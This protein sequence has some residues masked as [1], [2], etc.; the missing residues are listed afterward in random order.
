LTADALVAVIGGDGD[1]LETL[2]D[3]LDDIPTVAEF[4]LRTLPTADYTVVSDLPAAAPSAADIKTA[5]EA[6]GS[7]LDHL[8]EMTENDGGVRRLTANALEQA[9]SGG[10][11]LTVED[12]VDGVLDELLSG[13]TDVGSVGAGI[14][15]AGSAGDPWST[16]LPGAYGAGTAGKLLS[17]AKAAIDTKA[18]PGDPMTIA[19]RP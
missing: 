6:D 3:Q 19:R 12:I 7:K 15:A 1:T 2:S 17:D 14:A 16:A 10:G 11:S 8:W 4:E 5:L 18:E 9:P 13:H